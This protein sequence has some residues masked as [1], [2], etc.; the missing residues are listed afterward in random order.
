[1]LRRGVVVAIAAMLMAAPARADGTVY[2]AQDCGD[3]IFVSLGTSYSILQS[4]GASG[5]KEGDALQ[6]DVE[7]IGHPVL[8]DTTAGRSVFAQVTDHNL[9]RAEVTQRIAARCRAAT[10]EASVDGYV[11]RAT[12]CGSRI[13]VNTPQGYAVLARLAG[14]VVADGDTLIG[15]INHPGRITVID[16]QSGLTLVVFVEDLWLSKSAAG[17]KMTQSCRR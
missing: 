15:P 11:T 9:S 8:F 14:G 16:R 7:H 2:R 4:L 5:V 17:R 6:G 10:G 13:F 3:Y 1:M 12:G